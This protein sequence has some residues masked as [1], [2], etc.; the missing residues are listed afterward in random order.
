MLGFVSAVEMPVRQSFAAEL[1][2]PR[3]LVNAIALN[4]TNFN[5]ARVVGP[6]LA[7]LALAFFGACLQLRHQCRQLPGRAHRPVAD[8]PRGAASGG[9]RPE[10]F[11]SVRHSLAEGLRYAVRTPTV[12][13]PLVLLLGMA[14]FGMN[15]QTLLPLYVRDTLHMGA[16]GYGLLYATM[17]VGSLI[18]L[19]EAGLRGPPADAGHDAGRR[20]GVHRLRAAAGPHPATRP[21]APADPGHRP[22]LA[23]SWSTP[24]TSWCRTRR[25]ELRGPGDEPVRHGV[26]RLRPDRR[27][28]AGAVAERGARPA[29]S[30]GRRPVARDRRDRCPR[31]RWRAAAGRSA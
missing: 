12:L 6:G 17:G 21:V 31:L 24:S 26:R 1:V 15:F 23:W 7:G 22:V 9:A 14:T 29:A 30:C 20:R 18:G 28:F 4:S 5:L 25:D 19:A 27:L 13:W 2:P 10:R 8:G 16:E 3:D 11:D